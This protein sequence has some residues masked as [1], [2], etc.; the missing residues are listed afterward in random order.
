[1]EKDIH[2]LC[3]T[4]SPEGTVMDSDH[5]LLYH[6]ERKPRQPVKPINLRY[7]PS[8]RDNEHTDGKTGTYTDQWEIKVEASW[9]RNI[10][11]QN[12]GNEKLRPVGAGT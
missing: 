12:D 2:K 1:M 10:R 3:A 6:D 11:S 5:T 7:D 8:G 9:S 4:T